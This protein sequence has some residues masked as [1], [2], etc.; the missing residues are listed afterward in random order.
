MPSTSATQLSFGNS[1]DMPAAAASSPR[2]HPSLSRTVVTDNALILHS[3][4]IVTGDSL[5]PIPSTAEDVP[6]SHPDMEAADNIMN[7][8]NAFNPSLNLAVSSFSAL[9]HDTN[10]QEPP[11]TTSLSN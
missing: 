7:L 5:I 3:M 8:G 1:N 10:S 9:L 11:A 6:I 2:R 4:T